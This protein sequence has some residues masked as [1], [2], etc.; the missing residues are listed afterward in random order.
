MVANTGLACMARPGGELWGAVILHGEPGG[1]SPGR[2]TRSLSASYS[3]GLRPRARRGS[4]HRARV[5]QPPFS[6]SLVF[7]GG[8]RRAGGGG[9]V[10]VRPGTGLPG[11]AGTQ[12][13]AGV[14]VALVAGTETGGV[15]AAGRVG[16][17]GRMML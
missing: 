12:R 9:L 10:V 4:R 7:G 11:V 14:A 6:F 5:A 15:A 2:K 1:V 17:T 8:G 16:L 13:A 3:R